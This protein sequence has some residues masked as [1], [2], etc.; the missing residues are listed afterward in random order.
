[1]VDMSLR[2]YFSG[3]P[4][5]ELIRIH[6]VG[7]ELTIEAEFRYQRDGGIEPNLALRL[8]SAREEQLVARAVG[9]KRLLD[10]NLEAHRILRKSRIEV[11]PKKVDEQLGR[12]LRKNRGI[13]S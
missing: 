7:V 9:R 10:G 2:K 11:S 6:K 8:Y 12:L 5:R 1:M 13:E 4:D 3:L